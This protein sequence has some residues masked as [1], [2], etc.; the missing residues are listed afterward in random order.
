MKIDEIL[1]KFDLSKLLNVCILSLQGYESCN[2]LIEFEGVKK[3]PCELGL[4]Y[5]NGKMYRL[6]YDIELSRPEDYLSVYQSCCNHDC[7]MCHSWYFSRRVIGHW[8]SIEDIIEE[9]KKYLE[10]VTVWEPRERATMWH[11]SDL[12]MHCGMCV[13]K[14][15]RGPLCPSK[16]EPWQIVLSPQ[17]WG[18][19]RNIISF[20][21]GDL[22]C[23]VEFYEK[24]FM[25]LKEEVPR[26]WVK[27]ETN[28][29]GLTE[30]NLKKYAEAGLDSIWLDLKAYREDVYKWLTGTTNK[31]V[32]KVPELALKYDIVLEIVLLY[33]PGIVE[34]DQIRKFGEYIANIDPEIPTMLIAYFPQYKLRNR[35]PNVIEMIQGYLALKE[36]GLKRV[37][38]GNLGV[39]CKTEEDWTLLL[40][41]IDRESL[42]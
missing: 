14:G 32:L 15:K 11:A 22:Y 39:F 23:R 28:G 16:L 17:G 40:S 42:G 34:I 18:P 35:S 20:T 25:R 21:G 12:C 4:K 3:K 30:E 1:S 10:I 19:A 37:K 13:T 29:Y 2:C 8:Y 5:E 33:I 27:I 7:K 26:L 38:I 24:L 31:W 36:A 6:I 41:I 9:A